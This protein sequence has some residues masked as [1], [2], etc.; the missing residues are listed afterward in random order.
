MHAL[1]SNIYSEYSLLQSANRIKELVAYAKEAGYQTLAL[2]DKHVLYGVVPF[3]QEC[4][5]AGIKPVIG[6]ELNVMAGKEPVSVRL[7]AKNNVGYEQLTAISTELGCQTAPKGISLTMFQQQSTECIVL[8]S[9]ESFRQAPN[10]QKRWEALTLNADAFLE[11]EGR[12]D[13]EIIQFA[14]AH[15][16]RCVAAPPVRFLRKEE[17]GTYQLIR[18]IEAGTTMEHL[19]LEEGWEDQYFPTVAELTDRFQSDVLASTED[20]ARQID[21]KLPIEK[22]RIPAYDGLSLQESDEKL[23]ELCV[24]GAAVRYGKI[25]KEQ[26]DRL[27]KELNVIASM[28]YASYFLIV[29]DFV[30]YAKQNGIL[31]GPGRGSSASSIVAY[32]LFITDVDPLAHDLLFERFLNPERSVCR[33]LILTSQITDETKCLP[34]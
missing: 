11:L 6:L 21:V 30:N 19:S 1:L 15:T 10:W 7:I 17:A 22:P 34:M 13:Q 9:K 3:Y 26:S 18:A 27:E 29:A 2:T 28:G 4:V 5:K 25:E 8:L 16:I 31:T 14:S 32:T 33:I 23:R 12:A 24:K 20:V